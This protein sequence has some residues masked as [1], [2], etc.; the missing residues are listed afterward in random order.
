VVS[1][2]NPEND[3]GGSLSE[4][5]GQWAERFVKWE[6]AHHPTRWGN[7]TQLTS[8]WILFRLPLL[9]RS[10]KWEYQDRRFS[11]GPEIVHSIPALQ[12]HRL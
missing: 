11:K 12:R 2:E 7:T 8:V 1:W 6:E 9:L 5:V 10:C 4:T 3:L